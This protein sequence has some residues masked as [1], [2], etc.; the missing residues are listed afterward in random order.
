MPVNL[1]T[2]WLGLCA[3]L[4]LVAVAVLAALGQPIPPGLEATLVG[5]VSGHLALASP[6]SVSTNPAQPRAPPPLGAAQAATPGAVGASGTPVAAPA[7]LA[8]PPPA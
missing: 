7:L 4:N 3:V 5:L 6:T 1:G 2:V 8:V